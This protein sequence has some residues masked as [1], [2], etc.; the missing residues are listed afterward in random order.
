MSAPQVQS[1]GTQQLQKAQYFEKHHTIYR[2]TIYSR[3]SLLPGSEGYRAFLQYLDIRI[4]RVGRTLAL[5]PR[6]SYDHRSHR[7]A[8]SCL[9]GKH[10]SQRADGTSTLD[11]HFLSLKILCISLATASRCLAYRERSLDCTY[12]LEVA[13]VCEFQDISF[14]VVPASKRA[15]LRS[16]WPQNADQQ[17][18]TVH[19][20]KDKQ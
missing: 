5:S 7:Y 10:Y 11:G 13:K 1:H 19:S 2:K 18:E 4:W 20:S 6:S 16:T 17:L 3:L 8:Q 15:K 9:L 14:T 12:L